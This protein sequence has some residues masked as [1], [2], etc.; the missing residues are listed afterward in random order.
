MIFAWHHEVGL[1]QNT[2]IGVSE[3]SA[4]HISTYTAIIL[5]PRLSLSLSLSMCVCVCLSLACFSLSRINDAIRRPHVG[6][7][8]LLIQALMQRPVVL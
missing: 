8:L 1:L 6:T 4:A 2:D 7:N 3:F 5:L